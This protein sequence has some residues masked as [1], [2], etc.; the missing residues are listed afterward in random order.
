MVAVS[1][2][3]P[4]EL[5]Q[6][7][8]DAGQLHFGENY[9]Q[10]ICEKAPVMSK[11]IKWHFIGHLQSNKIKQLV[12]KVESLYMVETVDRV[13]IAQTLEKAWAATQRENKL[14]VLVQINT[15]N[16][17]SKSGI[18]TVEECEEVVKYIQGRCYLFYYQP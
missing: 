11:D 14:N 16:E 17:E 12:E 8:L 6:E 2:T 7:C 9:I 5:I 15:S 13:K 1:K 18:T 3:K 4:V 10:E